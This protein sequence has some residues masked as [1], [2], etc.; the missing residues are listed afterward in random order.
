MKEYMLIFLGADYGH[1]GLSP[2]QIQEKMSKWFA[3]GDKMAKDGILVGGKALTSD[4]KRV[5]GKDRLL[6]DGP[7]AESKE[8]VGG[9]YVI[10]VDSM[11]RAL[12]E[13]Q[14]Y[15]DFDLDGS[16]EVREVM[17]FQ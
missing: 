1:N 6:T 2:E 16:V 8:L 13:A 3:W 11:E 10:K 9:Y 15:P 5:V 14:N 7:A 12:E 17:V 4:G